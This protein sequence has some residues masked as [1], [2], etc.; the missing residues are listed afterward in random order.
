MSHRVAPT[1]TP[2]MRDT[3]NPGHAGCDPIETFRR[4]C[5]NPS[6]NAPDETELHVTLPATRSPEKTTAI[7]TVVIA[8]STIASAIISGIQWHELR[9]A[10]EIAA[11]QL[12]ESQKSNAASTRA[13]VGPTKAFFT[14]DLVKGGQLGFR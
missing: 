4:G 1:V 10:S 13:W 14:E 6:R 11:G 5:N 9:T 3:L 12:G 7:A 8:L 2:D